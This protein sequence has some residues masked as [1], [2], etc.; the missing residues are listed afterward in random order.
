MYSNFYFKKIHF[1]I[2]YLQKL[3]L[4][5]FLWKR[6][7]V[8]SIVAHLALLCCCYIKYDSISSWIFCM[9]LLGKM[10]ITLIVFINTKNIILG[11]E[12]CA[13]FS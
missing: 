4:E 8:L 7:A 6:A 12:A 10:H 2:T 5:M 9:I 1:N 3:S 11:C 13:F